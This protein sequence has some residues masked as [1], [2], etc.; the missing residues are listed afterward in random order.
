MHK[1]AEKVKHLFVK[2]PS[3]LITDEAYQ[4]ASLRHA[5]EMADVI[6]EVKRALQQGILPEAS[7]HGACGTYFL[8]DCESRPIAVFKRDHYIREVAAYRLDHDRFAGVPPT[9]VTTLEHSL[10]G[11]KAT[12]SCQYFVPDTV[13]VVEVKTVDLDKFFPSCVRRIAS[14]DIR[15]MNEDRHTS[16]MLVSSCRKQLIPID[17]GFILAQDLSDIHFDWLPWEQ[18]MTPFSERELSY[19]AL[20]DPERDRKLLIEELGVEE[21]RANRFFVATVFLQLGALRQLTAASLGN[22]LSRRRLGLLRKDAAPSYFECLIEKLKER[23]PPNWTIFSRIVYEE[24][25]R[26]LDDYE[27]TTPERSYKEADCRI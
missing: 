17:H 15:L 5:P 10:W 1:T 19:L 12:G 20:L 21:R 2:R 25:Q 24:V 14:L 7:P 11:G 18:A 26:T 22:F 23:N 16:N 27:K 3:L 9:V 8:K 6:W 4:L 13:T